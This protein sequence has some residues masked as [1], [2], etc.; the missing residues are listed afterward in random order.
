MKYFLQSA[1]W[2][3]EAKV[4][5]A[6]DEL[7]KIP[8]RDEPISFPRLQFLLFRI[9]HQIGDHKERKVVATAFYREL[10]IVYNPIHIQE[11]EWSGDLAGMLEVVLHEIG[12]LIANHFFDESGHGPIW[13]QIGTFLGYQDIKR[14]PV[15][16]LD[17]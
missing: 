16:T 11:L 2:S 14:K 4:L 15:A 1:I 12:H 10:K 6:L 3:A 9:E 13:V 8:G 17:G 5:G 7:N